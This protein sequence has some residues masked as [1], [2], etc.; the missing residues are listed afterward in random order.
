MAAPTR[1]DATKQYLRDKWIFVPAGAYDPEAPSL[2]ILDAASALDVTKMFF[3]SS[4]RPSQSTNLARAPKRIGDGASFEFVG[5]AQATVG[6]VRYSFN[7]QGAAASDGVLA[8]EKFGGETGGATGWL[9][10]RLG[11]DRDTDLAL[12]QFV[13]SYPV[14]AGEPMEVP[15]GD[16]EGAEVAI[17]QTFAQTGPKAMKKAIVA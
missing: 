17:A 16:G 9:V 8:F 6:E 12:A 15:E 11:I 10:N 14:E 5:E 3:A 2:A 13:T 1:P 7:P 4:A